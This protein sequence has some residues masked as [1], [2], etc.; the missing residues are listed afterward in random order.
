MKKLVIQMAR[1]YANRLAPSMA[2]TSRPKADGDDGPLRVKSSHSARPTA[3]DD[4]SKQVS[5]I[6]ESLQAVPAFRCPC[7]RFKTLRG[8]GQDEVCPVCFWEDD[9]QDEHDAD[10]VRGG[11]NGTLSL[12]KARDNFAAFRASDRRRCQHVRH[13]LPSEE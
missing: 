2:K 10:E 3:R 7:C 9:G 13:P 4:M 11:P 5:N 1:T 12:M 6:T 8:R